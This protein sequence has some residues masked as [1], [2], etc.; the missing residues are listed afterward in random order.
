MKYKTRARISR[1]IGNTLLFLILFGAMLGLVVTFGT[2][3]K[4]WNR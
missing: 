4:E 1:Y 3:M 2:I